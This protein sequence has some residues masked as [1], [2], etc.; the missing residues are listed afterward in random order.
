[1][2]TWLLLD[3]SNLAHR[4]F[5]ALGDLSY[6]G[7]PT[8]VLYGIFRDITE[9]QTLYSTKHCAFAFD[10]GY[11]K[12]VQLFPGY[13]RS[14]FVDPIGIT[15]EERE[16]RHNLKRQINQLRTR[17]LPDIGYQNV[18]RQEGVEADDVIA[19]VCLGLGKSD[20]VIIVSSDSDLL[21]LLSPR[22]II[23]NPVKKQ[24][25]TYKSFTEKWKISPSQWADVKAL[26]GCKTD[27][28][29]GIRS[30][31]EITAAKFLSGRLKT[32]S[33]SYEYIIACNNVWDRNIKLTRLPIP[34]TKKFRLVPDD[35]VTDSS[36][37]EV[38]DV[39]GMQSLM[40]GGK[41]RGSNS[42]LRSSH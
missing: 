28:V 27:D 36:W 37:N 15:P 8:E 13:K 35:S 4:A 19:S 33:K 20:E 38:M 2:Q 9:L 40:K 26:A 42:G 23:W 10:G 24:P 39:L 3:V 16:A 11:D 34:G 29:P 18:F 14:R 17:F 31:G 25:V 12:R 32:D 21:Q 6:D 22:V 30:I 7:E 1:M 5:H 41:R